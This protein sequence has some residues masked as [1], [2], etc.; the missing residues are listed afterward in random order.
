MGKTKTPAAPKAKKAKTAAQ[1]A[2]AEANIKAA[3]DRLAK[4][5]A[6]QKLIA[7]KRAEGYFGSETTILQMVSSEERKAE[8]QKAQEFVT[9]ALNGPYGPKIKDWLG[10]KIV[11][12]PCRIAQVIKN[13]IGS[14]G[15]KEAV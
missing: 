9:K 12:E 3:A 13:Y 5:Q 6:T 11:G 15:W 1:K 2:K 4:L 10:S 14:Q 7:Q 8:V